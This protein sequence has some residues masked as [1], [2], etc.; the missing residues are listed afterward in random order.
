MQPATPG[1]P[2]SLTDGVVMLNA[3]TLDDAA[4]HLAGEDEEQARR[5][6]WYPARST[7]ESV[8]AAILR[9][10]E[11]WR[12]GGPTRAFAA[13]EAATGT[14]VGG[15]ELRRKDD[16]IA[17]MSYWVFPPYRGRGFASRAARLVCAFA[18]GELGVERVELYVE[19]DNLASRGVARKAG[20]VEE[21][22]LRR[23]ARI[24]AERRDMVLYSRLPGD[25]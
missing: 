19:A 10:Q 21:G 25:V 4:A 11:A 9:W 18:F 15:C 13:R 14:L 8:R 2:P 24:G 5:F 12:S 3:F 22:V 7:L 20:F 17:H 1:E 23:Q 16:Q 6:G